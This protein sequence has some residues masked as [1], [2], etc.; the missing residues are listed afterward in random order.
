MAMQSGSIV[1]K[2]TR[3]GVNLEK[4]GLE[5]MKSVRKVT[6][7]WKHA[8]LSWHSLNCGSVKMALFVKTYRREGVSRLE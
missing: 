1:R 2:G 4:G 7:K 6:M 5:N 3:R 8:K